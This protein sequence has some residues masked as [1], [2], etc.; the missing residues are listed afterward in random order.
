M[1]L[2]KEFRENGH[3]VYIVVD[4]PWSAQDLHQSHAED[5]C[6]FKEVK[7]TVHVFLHLKSRRVPDRLFGTWKTAPMLSHR[8]SGQMIVVGASPELRHLIEG[9]FELTNYSRG[10][11]FETEEEGW[12]YMREVLG[13][14]AL[15]PVR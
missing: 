1:P 13:A 14:E 15:V 7:H 6:Y 2:H 9:M 5:G 12:Q 8:G 3:V 10:H 4:D 11:F